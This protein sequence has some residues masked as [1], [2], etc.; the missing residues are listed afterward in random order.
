MNDGTTE[1]TTQEAGFCHGQT[2]RGPGN[3]S[4][5]KGK[6]AQRERSRAQSRE[7]QEKNVRAAEKPGA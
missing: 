6:G 1:I 7:R 3:G 5:A 4:L 2:R